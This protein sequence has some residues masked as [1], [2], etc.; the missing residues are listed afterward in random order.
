[1]G[2]HTACPGSPSG[3]GIREAQAEYAGRKFFD[4]LTTFTLLHDLVAATS[5]KITPFLVHEKTIILFLYT[6]TNHGYHILS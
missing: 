1:V 2:G 3:G 4:F 6:F 5:V